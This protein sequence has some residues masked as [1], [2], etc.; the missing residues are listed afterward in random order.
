MLT[1]WIYILIGN[2]NT[3]KTTFQKRLVYHLTGHTYV[4]LDRN[5]D[6]KVV[7]KYAPKKLNRIFLMSRSFQ[8]TRNE[9]ETIKKYFNEY[10]KTEDICILSSHAHIA[11]IP[12][13][14]E[15]IG[16]GRERK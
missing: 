5:V 11:N 9:Y 16:E 15:M 3:G 14:K 13:I 1:K 7:H 12:E 4:R 10:F 2:N 6:F 8:E